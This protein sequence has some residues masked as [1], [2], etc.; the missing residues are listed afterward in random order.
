MNSYDNS[1]S[2]KFSKILVAIDGSQDSFKAADCALDMAKKFDA[3]VLAVTVTYI[4]AKNNLSHKQVLSKA[5]V[6]DGNKDMKNSELWF[7]NFV[8]KASTDKVD[9]KTELLNSTR[10]VDYVILEYAEEKGVDLI[11]LGT[12]G[13]TGFK[14]LLLGSVASSV[15][16]YAHC[17]VL[18]VK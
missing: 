11:V 18:I 5:L 6:E 17:P 4:P 1:N 9:L 14:R 7:D 13:R 3:Q 16:T 15:S 10:P 2:K 12:K 8:Q